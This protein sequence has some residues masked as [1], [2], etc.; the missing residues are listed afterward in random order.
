MKKK[1]IVILAIAVV[2]CAVGII[3]SSVFDWNVDIDKASGNIGKSSRF[4]RKTATESI[5]N[6][7]ELLQNDEDYKNSMVLAYSVM[8]TRAMQ[9]GTL[10]DMSNQA[11]ADIPEFEG[12]LKDMNELT[13]VITN[14]CESLIAAGNDL[15]AALEGQSCP[16][17]A[18]NTINASLAYTTLQKQ[19]DLANRFIE[20]ADDYMKKADASDELMFVRDQWVD[21]QQ[22]TAALEGDAKAAKELEE[23]G[24][25]LPADRAVSA[26]NSFDVISQ[27]VVFFATDLS[28]T[29]G[30]SSSLANAIP[31]ETIGEAIRVI[32][33]ATS[34]TLQNVGTTETLGGYLLPIEVFD[35]FRNTVS[36]QL[37]NTFGENTLASRSKKVDLASAATADMIG[38]VAQES[39]L[40]ARSATRPFFNNTSSVG[41]LQMS[42]GTNMAISNAAQDILMVNNVSKTLQ[43]AETCNQL[44]NVIES[45][46]LGMK[47]NLNIIIR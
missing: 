13:P 37:S 38:N 26:L 10:V 39:V 36:D 24:S 40:N 28:N 47:A 9:F 22:M 7:E 42:M 29:Y 2:L 3:A 43:A 27:V 31:S 30:V 15:N 1:S 18:Q 5:T 14:V 8:R 33:N 46:S 35:V 16:D 23:K 12:V 11:A 34:E 17:L 32:N 4:S 21:Y 20:V 45:T 44:N 19:N 41:S 25:V 6:M